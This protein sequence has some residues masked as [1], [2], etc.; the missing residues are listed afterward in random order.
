MTTYQI[1]ISTQNNANPELNVQAFSHNLAKILI[2][3]PTLQVAHDLL[4]HGEEMARSAM[5]NWTPEP[6][7]PANSE[8]VEQDPPALYRVCNIS[9]ATLDRIIA[10]YEATPAGHIL[11]RN[12]DLAKARFKKHHH[13]PTG[14]EFSYMVAKIQKN[15]WDGAY[16]LYCLAFKRGY[17]AAKREQRKKRKDKT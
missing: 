13:S 5:Q 7:A 4:E 10:E 9:E 8:P 2:I 17:D 15:A 1:I 6:P 16:D 11:S 12:I 14:Q 3:A